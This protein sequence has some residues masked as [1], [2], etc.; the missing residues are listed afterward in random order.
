MNVIANIIWLLLG[1]L[2]TAFVWAVAGL[3]LCL[4]VVGA[5]LGVQCL[6]AAQLSLAPFGK[7]V[8]YEGGAGSA[9]V[10]FVWI[11][12][13]GWWLAAG[14]LIAGVINCITI[15]GIPSGLQSFKMMRLAWSPFGAQIVG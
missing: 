12:L 8:E 15:I 1:G 4:T 13:V 14:Y 11:I 10:N 9:I 7:S 5:P 6:K 2:E 3:F